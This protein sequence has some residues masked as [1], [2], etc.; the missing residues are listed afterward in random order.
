M[1]SSGN[2]HK[3][4]QTLNLI[5][6][7]LSKFDKT[8]VNEYG[9]KTKNAFY[10][11]IVNLGISETVGVVKNR[12]D[13]FDGMNPD[14]T[15]KGW[16]QKGMAYKHRKDFI[17]AQF[18]DLNVAEYISVVKLAIEADLK[19]LAGL[20]E[21]TETISPLMHSRF[22]QIQETGREAEYYFINNFRKIDKFKTAEISDARLFGDGYDFQMKLSDCYYLAEIKGLKVKRGSI[23][24]TENE[25]SKACQYKDKYLLVVIS[26]LVD[27]PK[28]TAIFNP[29]EHITL[30]KGIIK[31]EQI[32]FGSRQYEW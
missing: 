13:L 14:S 26:N 18:G 8:F 15:R 9:F 10:G 21:A 20:S 19:G 31:S 32:Y 2:K 3:Y 27:K 24:L 25:H 1:V 29:T 7:G 22:K 11:Y 16:H 17:D 12:Q 4:Y 5:G 23:R 6:Y 30:K 28:M